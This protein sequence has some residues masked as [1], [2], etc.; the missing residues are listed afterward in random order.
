M[1]QTRRMEVPEH[2]QEFLRSQ[3]EDE[4]RDKAEACET[5][6]LQD[7]PDQEQ[8][9]VHV[10]CH[11]SPSPC[12]R[13]RRR[14]PKKKGRHRLDV[15]GVQQVLTERNDWPEREYTM[16]ERELATFV[17]DESEKETSRSH[18]LSM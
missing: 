4:G 18:K 13:V 9:S 11:S 1:R 14:S 10:T 16:A 17:F 7:D 2:I 3:P 6:F 8:L 15:S 12:S 5:G